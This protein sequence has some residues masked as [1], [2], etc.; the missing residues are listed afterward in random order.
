MGLFTKKKEVVI[1]DYVT[2]EAEGA[3][4]WLVTWK[5][6]T[7]E[8]SSNYRIAAKAFVHKEDADRFAESLKEAK[9]LLQY[10]ENLGISIERQ[11]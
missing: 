9:A 10:T 5:A 6:R 1:E 7:G 2:K 3:E 8:Y 4:V 11:V